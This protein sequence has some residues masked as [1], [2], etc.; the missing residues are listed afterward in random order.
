LLLHGRSGFRSS[1]THR[2]EDKPAGSDF[3]VG[4]GG[5][6]VGAEAENGVVVIDHDS[7]G[8]DFDSKDGSEMA[9]AVN[10]P[11]F[12][13]GEVAT[14]EGI[15]SIKECAAD[16]PA[17]AV[18]DTFLSF[19]DIFAARQSHGSPSFDMSNDEPTESA[20]KKCRKNEK[21]GV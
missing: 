2:T 6:D 9:Q 19:L 15:E 8:T 10:E 3:P 12:A 13:V 17:E 5:Y 1:A 16:T 7:E 18:I 11:G 14:C 4:P 21:V 20:N